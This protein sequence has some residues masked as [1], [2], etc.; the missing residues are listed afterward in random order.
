MEVTKYKGKASSFKTSEISSTE[1]TVK[2]TPAFQKLHIDF[3]EELTENNRLMH[4][5]ESK[6]N[7]LL[8]SEIIETKNG[9]SNDKDEES[10]IINLLNADLY[11]LRS[12]KNRF[13]R[14]IERLNELV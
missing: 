9:Q 7:D 3:E 5:L 13:I 2:N 1:K 11:Y 6:I 8:G 12:L 4:Q 14:A 10:S